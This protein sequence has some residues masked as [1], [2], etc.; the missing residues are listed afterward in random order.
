MKVKWRQ[1]EE[2]RLRLIIHSRQKEV[3]NLTFPH[4]EHGLFE[5]LFEERKLPLNMNTAGAVNR[6]AI[7]FL[8][9]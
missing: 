8:I 5:G 7:T 6:K 9:V 4:S 1:M 2:A 3:G